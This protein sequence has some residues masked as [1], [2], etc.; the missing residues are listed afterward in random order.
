MDG[1]LAQYPGQSLAVVAHAT[2]LTLY[3]A[4]LRGAAPRYDDWRAIG[5]AA[6][7]A[8]DRA[9]LRPR[10]KPGGYTPPQGAQII[11]GEYEVRDED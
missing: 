9:S 5:F 10:R 2:V 11:E 8:V 3:A 7:M 6:I 4:R 1:V